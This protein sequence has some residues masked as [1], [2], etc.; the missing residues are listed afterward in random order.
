LPIADGVVLVPLVGAMDAGRATDMQEATLARASRADT[1]VVLLD[2]TGMRDAGPEVVSAL[3]RAS[4]ALRLLGVETVL[5]GVSAD[6][7][8]A[9]VAVQAELEGIATRSTLKSGIEY[10]LRRTARGRSA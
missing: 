10:A 8:R 3:I 1:R 6:T 2:V 9:L 7:A 5:T 4:R